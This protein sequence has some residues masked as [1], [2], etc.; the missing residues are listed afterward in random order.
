[1]TYFAIL[2]TEIT[3]QFILFGLIAA[4]S[5]IGVLIMIGC[6]LLFNYI[7]KL[8]MKKELLEDHNTAFGATLA[9]LFIAIAIIVAA[10]IIG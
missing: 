3:D 6:A 9:G 4:Y 5:V 10:S 8:N 1:M 7:F 2:S